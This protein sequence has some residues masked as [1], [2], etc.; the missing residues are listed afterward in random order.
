[1]SLLEEVYIQGIRS[2]GPE[3]PQRIELSTP[4]TLILGPNGTGKTVSFRFQV[5]I[6]LIKTIIECLKYAVTGEL[7]PGAKTGA[8][9]IHDPKVSAVRL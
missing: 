5:C 6:Y 4:V 7:P 3:N 9:F 8:S 2:F 1:M